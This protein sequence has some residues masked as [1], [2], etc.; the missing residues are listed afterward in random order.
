MRILVITN[1]FPPLHAGTFEFRCQA[2]VESLQK[3]GHELY[4]LTS[5]YGLGTEQKD[6]EIARRLILN[7]RFEQP[8]V[9]SYG[10]LKEIEE[11]N[12][13]ALMETVA[14]FQP[15]LIH[16]WSL[17]G[18]SKSLI[19]SLRNTKIPTV[20]DVA[21]DWLSSGLREDP[22]LNWWNRDSAPI[23]SAIHRKLLELTGQRDKVNSIAPTRMMKG[24]ER[25]PQLYGKKLSTESEPNSIG[26]FHFERI[27]FCSQALKTEAEKA[28]FRVAHAEVIYPGIP[29]DR[30]YN[31]IKP[32]SSVPRRFLIVSRLSAQ[33]GV[34]TALEALKL[35]LKNNAQASLTICGKGESEQ[36]AQLRSFVIQHS[37]PVE[38][39]SM[40][41][42]QKEVAQVYRRHDAYIYCT[43]WDEPFAVAPLEAMASGLPIIAARSGGVSELLRAGQ[44]GWAYTPGDP[45]EL[46]SRI[47]ELQMQPALRL[48]MAE[49]AQADVM[50]QFSESFMLDQIESYL[51]TTLEVWRND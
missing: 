24:Y 38:F 40:S 42:Q 6:H 44:N 36:M 29:T 39:I 11:Y 21:D 26:A 46:A 48:Q 31:D 28:G 9:T 12:T 17:Q 33:S 47:M 37:L 14:Q 1:L 27:Y 7:G 32:G 8:L 5:R 23:G 20:Y 35:A 22:W 2:V 15:E 16:V 41:N 10:D 50:N 18:L 51:N 45:V 49:A 34:M 25:V 30:F 43:E 3:R 13:A 19:F 4:V